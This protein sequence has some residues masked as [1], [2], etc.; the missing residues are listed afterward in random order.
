MTA[1]AT[2]KETAKVRYTTV[3]RWRCPKTECAKRVLIEATRPDG[4]KVYT[5]PK[6]GV[7]QPA[8]RLSE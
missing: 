2:P 1:A 6:H 8:A 5:C 4:R 3:Y 7:I